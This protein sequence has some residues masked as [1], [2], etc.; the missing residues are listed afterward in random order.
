MKKKI[1]LTILLV[2]VGCFFVITP[3]LVAY[4]MGYRF[5]FQKMKI[6]ATGGIYVRTFPAA[7]QIIIDSKI[8]QKPGMFS[9]SIFVQSLLPNEHAVLVKK[10]SYYDYFKTLPVQEK[11]VTKIEN[12]LLFKKDTQF[13]II[14]D[15]TKSPFITQEKFLIKNNN[16]YYS[17]A[18]ENS[19][20]T[21]VQKSTPVLKKIAALALQNNNIIWLGTDGFLYKS[22]LSASPAAE[23]AKIIL[24]PLKIVKT[25]SYK[26]ISDSK[27]I[28]IN[29]NG[30][31][32]FLN[33]KTNEL[34]DFAGQVKDAKISPDDKNIVY[35]SGKNLYI[36]LLSK[37]S[38]EKVLLYKSPEEITDCIWLNNDYIIVS[39][40]NKIIISEIDYR[41]N[42]NAVTLP[43]TIIVSPDKK[44]EIKNP[45]IFFNRQDAKLYILTGN[46]LLLS[47]KIIP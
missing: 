25:G 23:P 26:I 32:L 29:N 7:D 38:D 13:T 14:T 46:T 47:E 2:C 18:P 42:I 5:D 20:L 39:S 17:D 19:E 30:N 22:D 40:A 15:K 16:L 21:A 31:L 1:R 27:N 28:F 44:I 8:T 34:D 12:V 6:T 35:F 41:G 36:F 10:T 9:N 37:E 33:T 3:V 43:A 24:T 11:E 45:Q 4:S